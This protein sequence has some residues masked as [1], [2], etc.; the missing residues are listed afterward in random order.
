MKFDGNILFKE[1]IYF[2]VCVGTRSQF[3]KFKVG[4][5]HR[6]YT[7]RTLNTK[8]TKPKL[9]TEFSGIVDQW[10]F[11]LTISFQVS[12]LESFRQR[13]LPLLLGGDPPPGADPE[14]RGLVRLGQADRR[15]HRKTE[16]R[17]P[18]PLTGIWNKFFASILVFKVK[19]FFS[20]LFHIKLFLDSFPFFVFDWKKWFRV[21]SFKLQKVVLVANVDVKL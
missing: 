13:F 4:R 7:P 19:R 5:K 15:S 21:K 1:E 11:Y 12:Q 10:Q 6:K 17:V 14:L 3:F 2:D 9:A 20:K 8:F 16:F 18:Q